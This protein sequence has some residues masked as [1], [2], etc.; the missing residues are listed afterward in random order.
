MLE[1]LDKAAE[2]AEYLNV[3]IHELRKLARTTNM[4]CF[5]I[6]RSMRFDRA[7][8]LAWLSTRGQRSSAGANAAR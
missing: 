1:K 7:A 2:L 5:R 8:V 6:G 4:P 3:S